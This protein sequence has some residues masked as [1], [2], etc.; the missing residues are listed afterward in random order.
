[1]ILRLQISF[2]LPKAYNSVPSNWRVQRAV[3][4]SFPS[5][6]RSLRRELPLEGGLGVGGG[7]TTTPYL[8]VTKKRWNV[9]GI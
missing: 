9:A 4:V 1:M 5:A 6:E 7:V 8:I 2:P 3:L